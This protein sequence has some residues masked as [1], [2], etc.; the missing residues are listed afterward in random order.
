MADHSLQIRPIAG[1]LGAEIAGIDL[2]GDLDEATIAAIRQAWLDHL[3]ILFRGQELPPERFLAFARH[4]GEVVEY[5]FINGIEGFPLIAR[6][7]PAISPSSSP[8]QIQPAV[9]HPQIVERCYRSAFARFC[10]V[11]NGRVEVPHRAL[12]IGLKVAAADDALPGVEV[13]QD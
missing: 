2:S 5:P 12:K 7:S 4:F 9:P 8:L 6:S 11:A 1:A 10:Q 13:D 3:V